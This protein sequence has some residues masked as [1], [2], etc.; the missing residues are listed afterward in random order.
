M[1][2]L[3]NP[4]EVTTL[5]DTAFRKNERPGMIAPAFFSL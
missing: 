5:K 3:K 2:P 4:L 1:T